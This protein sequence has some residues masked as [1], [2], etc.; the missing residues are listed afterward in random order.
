MRYRC[1]RFFLNIIYFPLGIIPSSFRLFLFFVLYM[2]IV[3]PSCAWQ[4][5]VRDYGAKGDG[6]QIDSHA[7]NLAI[8]D[9]S[10]HGG[11]VVLVPAGVYMCYSIHLKSNVT[12]QVDSGAV[13]RAAMPTAGQTYDLPEENESSYQDFGHSH[14]QNSL[15]C[16]ID[17]H[18]VM[19]CGNGLIDG[20]DVLSRGSA[21]LRGLPVANKAL[22]LREC[23]HVVVEG[24][25]FLNCGHFAMLFT[26]VD[27][28]LVQDV[29][30]DSNRD[31]IDIDCC[32]D[33]VVRRC[34]VNTL[35]DDAIVLKSSYALGRLKA[36]ARV[37]V[38]D[39]LVS[40][41]DVGSFLNGT[42]T[43][44]TTAAPDRDGPTG[45]IKLGTESNGGFH[46]IVIRRCEL[47]HCRGVALETVDGGCMERVE[48]SDIVMTDICNAPFYV[49][50]GGRRRGPDG[51]PVSSVRGI[52]FANIVVKDADSR[53]ASIVAGLDSC[54][55]VS[56]VEFCDVSLQYRGGI[57]LDDVATQRGSNTFFTRQPD[58]PEPAAHG[59]QPA[60]CFVLTNV[61]GIRFKNVEIEILSSDERPKVVMQNARDVSFSNVTY[62]GNRSIG[63]A[64][65]MAIE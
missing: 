44:N 4:C 10:N 39:C 33:V 6:V 51:T 2:P 32:E 13:I 34:S 20:T 59:I 64:S 31:G 3:L 57:T 17:L 11:G 50:L 53:Y 9:A 27:S 56:D 35:N 61:E 1:S 26:G 18:D 36:T 41:Y 21:R 7:I 65:R 60:S 30:I 43:V 48:V 47:R 63:H 19:I 37:V 54:S 25:R 29:T 38:E 16:G 5:S 62:V 46:D 40:G 14:W 15:I 55:V 45:R 24:L 12:L 23:R 49:R 58:Y 42:M 8:D 22:A 28:L 52:R